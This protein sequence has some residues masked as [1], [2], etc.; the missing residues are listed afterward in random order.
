MP[1]TAKL[2]RAFYERLGDDIADELVAWMN[3]VDLAFRTELR[4]LNELS[5]ARFD[6]RMAE[7]LATLRAK[8]RSEIRIDL[9]AALD[10]LDRHETRLDRM[11]ERFNRLEEMIREA[12][13]SGIK[14]AVGLWSVTI[15]VLVGVLLKG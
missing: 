10:R 9:Q 8:L 14:W 15:L 2:S 3:A 13:V 1:V 5:F 12:R 7:R 6:A 11:D 4:E